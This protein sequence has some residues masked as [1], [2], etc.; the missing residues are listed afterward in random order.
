MWLAELTDMFLG[1]DNGDSLFLPVLGHLL[2]SFQDPQRV[3]FSSSQPWLSP[4]SLLLWFLSHPPLELSAA[5]APLCCCHFCH[6]VFMLPAEPKAAR[7]TTDEN[8]FIPLL[9]LHKERCRRMCPSKRRCVVRI[10]ALIMADFMQIKYCFCG[11]E[12]WHSSS[13]KWRTAFAPVPGLLWEEGAAPG[14]W[15]GTETGA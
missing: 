10:L 4:L 9:S 7:E 1:S 5:L 6:P 12:R 14:W 8:P 2:G 15:E 11:Y 13:C 3:I